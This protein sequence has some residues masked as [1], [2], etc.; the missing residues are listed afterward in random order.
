MKAIGVILAGGNNQRL[1]KLTTLPG[2]AVA[3]MPVGSGYRAIDFALSNMTNSGIRKV[4]VIAQFSSSSLHDHL[5]SA[6]WWDLGRKKGGL[7]LFTP[8]SSSYDS[9]FFRGTSN[10]IYQNLRF[11]TRSNEEYVII[12]SGDS[13]YKMDFNPLINHHVERNNDMTIMYQERPD[14]D[15]RQFGVLTL[16]KDENIIDFEEKPLETNLK[17]ISLGI[18]V[19]KRE[20]LIELLETTNKEGRYDFVRDVIGRYRKVLKFGGY[21][22]D[23]YWNTLNSISAYYKTNMDFLNKDLRNFFMKEYPY[24]ATKPKDEPPV[25]YNVGAQV[26]NSLVGG[27][28]ILNGCVEN[29]LLFSGV[30]VGEHAYIKGSIVM[31]GAVIGNNCVIENAILDKDTSIKDGTNIVGTPENPVIIEK[32]RHI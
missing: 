29:S 4:A 23:S 22:F 17:T 25:K 10:A 2:R 30:Y 14:L 32:N 16:D 21:K 12:S 18:Y 13:V 5:S 27:G 19:I 6:K 3:A 28:S 9:S 31:Q 15:V 8:F 26:L 11:F 1:E 7:F 20:L 24:I